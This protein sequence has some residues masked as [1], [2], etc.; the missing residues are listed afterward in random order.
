MT[1]ASGLRSTDYR[2]A[3]DDPVEVA[4][5]LYSAA[6][7]DPDWRWIQG[8]CLTFLKSKHVGVRWVAA[9]CLG[10]LATFH[11]RLDLDLVL[12][13]LT[14]AAGDPAI[15]LAVQDSLSCIRQFVKVQ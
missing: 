4:E 8:W 15:A 12:P 6:H 10:D 5:A 13:A 14:E 2:F 9:T 1:T 3:S 11:K 7:H